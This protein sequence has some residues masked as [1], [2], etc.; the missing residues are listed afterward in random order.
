MA[1]AWHRRGP[2]VGT[3]IYRPLGAPV[4]T[5]SN[6]PLVAMAFSKDGKILATADGGGSARLWNAATMQPIGQPMVPRDRAVPCAALGSYISGA[7]PVNGV[8]I[9]PDG[10]LLTVWNRS[11]EVRLWSTATPAARRPDHARQRRS[12]QC[13][14]QPGRQYAAHRRRQRY[15]PAVGR[16]HPAAGRQVRVPG[17]G[18]RSPGV[19]Q[20]RR[21]SS[22]NSQYEGHR[23]TMGR[24]H[25]A[26]DRQAQLPAAV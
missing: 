17:R 9:S 23:P 12:L 15:S 24:A 16:A 3:N 2:V 10:K 13:R 22:R 7:C 14:V 11:G 5:G 25:P 20:P 19:F 1:R 21:T 6:T 18:Q 4:T 26:A 8:A